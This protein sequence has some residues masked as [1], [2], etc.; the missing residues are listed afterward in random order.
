M[1]PEVSVIIACYNGASVIEKAI[2]SALSQ[3]E[4][5]LEIVVV[6]DASTDASADV[7]ARC[8]KDGPVRLIRQP[9]NR[10]ISATRN[11][12][13]GAAEGAFIAFLDQ[14]DLW[15]P[16]R[17]ATGL[18]P[19]RSDPEERIGLVFG[20]EETRVLE[21]GALLA[22]RKRPPA[23]VN[24]L[25][26]DGFLRALI[27]TN[28]IPT[29]AALFR[30]RCFDELGPL[31]ESLKSGIDDFEMFLRVARHFDVR[32]VDAV[33]AIRHVHDANYTKLHRMVPEMLGVL[34]RL[35]EEEPAL[36]RVA[37][38]TRSEYLRLLAWEQRD[39]QDYGAARRTLA[40]AL[41]GRPF[42]ARTWAALALSIAGP[43][44]STLAA[45]LGNRQNG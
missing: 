24:A 21:T 25:D 11:T 14:D 43:A 5:S 19:F 44:R 6:D 23:D 17:L 41:R 27:G 3:S 4:T 2:G 37:A 10:G 26:R 7:V 8:A 20:I 29:A 1:T 34:T 31:D 36:A 40:Q 15:Y 22:G 12:G 18:Q 35:S 13:I 16:G 42:D 38:E 45:L 28:F 30:K 9:R 39:A 33:Q 32:F